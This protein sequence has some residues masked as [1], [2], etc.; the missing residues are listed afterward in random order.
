MLVYSHDRLSRDAYESLLI[1]HTLDK[2]KIEIIY[3]RPGEQINSENE[4]MNTFLENLLSN[5]S[6]LESNIIGG[7]TFMGNLGNVIN[8]FWAGGPAP[9]GYT[10][11]PIP[12]NRRKRKL[13]INHTEARI[14]KKI[15]RLYTLGYSP[16]NIVDYIKTEYPYNNDRL[17]TINSIK[18]ILSNPVYTGVITWN[19]KGGRRNP[20]KKDSSQYTYSKFDSN[21]QIIDTSTWD[22]TQELKNIQNKKPKFLSTAFLLKDIIICGECGN[23]FKTKNHGNSSGYVYYCSHSV[24]SESIKSF[25]SNIT[26]TTIKAPIIHNIVF[27]ELRNLI[28]SLIDIDTNI[29]D[30]YNKYFTKS[31]LKKDLLA[32]EKLK[33]LNDISDTEIMIKKASSELKELNENPLAD[34]DDESSY[35]KYL[36]LLLSIEEFLTHLNLI[37]TQLNDKLESINKKL[38]YTIVSKESFRDYLLNSLSPLEMLLTEQNTDIRNRCLRL[39]FINI[40]DY[41]KVSANS[42]IEISFK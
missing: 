38:L 26:T 30:L 11:S 5:L 3:S 1:K 12:A 14:V 15:F 31:H 40:I 8:N 42:S 32:D 37:K 24:D 17:W 19:K 27:T 36:Y 21:I 4:S 7:R 20:R 34:S 23:V 22:K 16:K 9:Y 10:L 29:D 18:S 2:L 28:S 33:L 25:D 35:D 41:I 39:L 13:V 6:A